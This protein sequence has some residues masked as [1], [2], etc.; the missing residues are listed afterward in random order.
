VG[1]AMRF[2]MDYGSLVQAMLSPYIDKQL[3]GATTLPHARMRC[4]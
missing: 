1:D 4:A 3:A 2:D